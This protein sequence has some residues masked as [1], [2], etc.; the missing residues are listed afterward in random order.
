MHERKD[1]N[2][3]PFFVPRL[4]HQKISPRGYSTPVSALHK[5]TA[6]ILFLAPSLQTTHH[7]LAG[8]NQNSGQIKEQPIATVKHPCGVIYSRTGDKKTKVAGSTTRAPSRL[9]PQ[10]HRL[11]I[12]MDVRRPHREVSPH[13][14]CAI[15]CRRWFVMRIWLSEV[16]R[17][18]QGG[19]FEA[20]AGECDGLDT[21]S[22]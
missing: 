13:H 11:H 12:M 16:A 17:C 8:V 20:A 2:S 3:L 21:T 22:C 14:N 4:G 7:T 18:T 10:P 6:Y 15:S 9:P 1:R 5:A 19:L